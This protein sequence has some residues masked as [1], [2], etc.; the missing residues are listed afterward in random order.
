VSKAAA[1][2]SL[3]HEFSEAKPEKTGGNRAAVAVSPLNGLGWGILLNQR[4]GSIVEEMA[5]LAADGSGKKNAAWANVYETTKRTLNKIQKG[6]ESRQST[7]DTLLRRIQTGQKIALQKDESLTESERER[8]LTIPDRASGPFSAIAAQFF[9][10]TSSASSASFIEFSH[11]IDQLA[12]RFSELLTSGTL[13]DAKTVLQP[14]WLDDDYWTFPEDGYDD[15]L[16]NRLKMMDAKTS[17]QLEDALGVF[18]LNLT[19]SWLSKFDLAIMADAEPERGQFPLFL[20][21]VARFTPAAAAAIREGKPPP[22]GN[23]AAHFDLPV[24]NLI[25]MLRNISREVSRRTRAASKQRSDREGKDGMPDQEKL[26]QLRKH[27][28]LSAADFE[29]LLLALKPDYL[30][31]AKDRIGFDVYALGLAANAFSML[32]LR[33]GKPPTNK[34]RRKRPCSITMNDQISAVYQSFWHRHLKEMARDAME[35]PWPK[36]FTDSLGERA[37]PGRRH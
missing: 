14:N 27:D 31:E 13:E 37:H 6:R 15:S 20:P 22:E 2:Q 4:S 36:W 35:H 7:L 21:L 32:T 12:T 8:I 9:F 10:D 29:D 19:L 25:L 24:P 23:W 11:D 1:P 34:N 28:V 30:P 16:V 3:G 5:K 17:Q 26:N 33:N 18:K